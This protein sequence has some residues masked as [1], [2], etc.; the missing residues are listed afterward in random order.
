MRPRGG[1]WTSL[2]VYA[3]PGPDGPV[4]FPSPY[5]VG[6]TLLV[7][8]D[9]QTAPFRVEM[10]DGSTVSL[11]TGQGAILTYTPVPG[12]RRGGVVDPVPDMTREPPEL[13][14]DLR[15]LPAESQLR[16]AYAPGTP[17]WLW[18]P[19]TAAH[20]KQDVQRLAERVTRD[21]ALVKMVP[22][23]GDVRLAGPPTVE[24]AGAVVTPQRPP[25][26]SGLSGWQIA[27]IGLGLA[28][29]LAAL[30]WIARR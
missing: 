3:E 11:A 28:G 1:A 4:S 27:G 23:S 6:F 7:F 21:P 24:C 9:S 22:D 2:V 12:E 26:R 29:A 19:G 10:A 5:D 14:P 13:V 16:A 25:V 15:Q 30:V 17:L 18:G 8:A 20:V